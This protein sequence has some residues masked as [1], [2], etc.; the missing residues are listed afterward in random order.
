MQKNQGLKI[1]F[2]S[3]EISPFAKTGGLADV[4]GSLPKALKAS[5]NDIRLVMPK[6]K[7][8]NPNMC[9]VTDFPIK[10]G[11]E[12]KTCIVKKDYIKLKTGNQYD[13]LPV[14]FID[15]YYYYNR[16]GLY[17]HHDDGERFAFFCRAVVKMLPTINF[18]PDII[19]CNDWH[20]GPVC[21]LLKEKSRKYP[22]YKDISS[23]FTIHNL[24][25]QGQ[26]DRDIL[27]YFEVDES[28]FTPDK[29]EFYGGFNFAKAGLV[30]SDTISTV[31]ST[32]AE[33]IKT[34]IYGEGLD[35]VLNKRSDDLFGIINGISYNE[36]NPETDSS[37]TKNYSADSLE[38][39][40][41]NSTSLQ[42]EM[43]LPVRDVPIIGVV[44]R[45]TGQKGLELI[46]DVIEDIMRYD[47]QFIL[48]G[49][50]DPYYEDIFTNIGI[51]YPDKAGIY[52]GFNIGLAQ[53]IYAGSDMFLMPSRFEP[54]GLGQLISLRYGTIPVVRKTG[55]LADTIIDYDT[56]NEDGNGF[57]FE[58]FN[59]HKMLDA[60]KRAL[61]LYNTNHEKWKQLAGRGM[62]FDYSW[63]EQAEKYIDLYKTTLR[64]KNKE[65]Q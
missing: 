22:F 39:K 13:W 1:L 31:S 57:V 33:E 14:Y 2:I 11:D 9:Y 63:R 36:F 34:S 30:Y 23:I 50:G 4:A 38:D 7:C 18:K 54:C 24:E 28:V 12:E 58:D 21:M 6:Y 51:K 62:K 64:R 43:G 16:K 8:I 44:S 55:G 26:F 42:V 17:C 59:S 52:I 65:S 46:A 5:G 45:L 47:L 60:V 3:S 10:M 19:H 29:V 53:R 40:K 27:R 48:L 25:Y 15:N 61:K 56:D 32:Y 49:T 41:H 20:S 35:G 37:I